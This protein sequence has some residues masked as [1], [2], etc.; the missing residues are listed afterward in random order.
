MKTAAKTRLLAL[1]AS[2]AE[3]LSQM[4]AEMETFLDRVSRF[5]I[6]AGMSLSFIRDEFASA[7][8]AGVKLETVAGVK[9]KDW[10]V[11]ARESCAGRSVKTVY[12][13]TNAGTVARILSD[14]DVSIP[15]TA[16][17]GSLVPLYRILTAIDGD[18]AT[19]NAV[20]CDVYRE[21][22]S[23]AGT[24][25]DGVQ[26]APSESSV[27]TAA[28]A[29][30]PTN[31]SGGSS[32]ETSDETVSDETDEDDEDDESRRETAAGLVV[33]DAAAVEAAK[34]PTDAIIRGLVAEYDVSR[35][36]VEAAMSAAI[37]LASEWT[38]SVVAHVLAGTIP[39]KTDEDEGSDN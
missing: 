27:H 24:D 3:N 32:D 28:E 16:R 14:G 33:V 29:A 4:D 37:R 21:C 13:W 31:R 35:L 39:A 7:K 12:R 30:A 9:T 26:I 25:D 17:V 5:E 36:A 15:E 10:R 38:V 2:I 1:R 20:V 18:T 8:T 19:I 23:E 34:G 22:L 11:F 6:A